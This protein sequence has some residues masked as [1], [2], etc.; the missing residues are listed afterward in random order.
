M[1]T[2]SQLFKPLLNLILLAMPL[3][4]APCAGRAEYFYT[5][6][7]DGLTIYAYDVRGNL[8]IPALINGIRVTGIEAG[9]FQ[10]DDSV[11]SVILPDSVSWV[12]AGAFAS[13]INLT[14]V[15][16]SEGVAEIA[17]WTFANCTSLTNIYIP[18]GVTNIANWAFRDCSNLAAVY[19]RGCP[20]VVAADVFLGAN[21]VT[22]YY[23]LGC[24]GVSTIG[25]RPAVA[26]SF[27]DDYFYGFV[28]D[29]WSQN[30]QAG[31]W[32]CTCG[33]PAAIGEVTI[34]GTFKGLPVTWIYDRAFG[35]IYCPSVTSV[36][37]PAT[38]TRIGDYAFGVCGHMTN[39]NFPPAGDLTSIGQ[40]AFSPCPLTTL[41]LPQAL[42]TIGNSA[43][44]GC[45]ALTQVAFGTNLVRIGDRAFE[46]SNLISV[47]LP[48]SLT[49]IGVG[50]FGLSSQL[51]ALNI[52]PLNP[53]YTSRDGVLFNKSGT[54][55]TAYPM[56]KPELSYTVPVGVTSI[57]PEAF[58]GCMNLA[59]FFQGNA[60]AFDPQAFSSSYNTVLYYLPGTTG[61][62]AAVSGCLQRLWNPAVQ[63]ADP[64][65]GP[66]AGGFGLPIT[67]TANI[68]IVLEV[69]SNMSAGSWTPLQSCTLTN[70]SVFITDLDWTNRPACFYRLRSP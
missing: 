17:A 53:A 63:T 22:A 55:L 11:T 47:D 16:I 7:N 2:A 49:N 23:P 12:G 21:K 13:C 52:D 34:P 25:G 20:P 1:K 28:F 69:S 56:G 6:N 31:F 29:W 27:F 61:W 51:R 40:E 62:E 57:Q 68:P 41:S 10:D 37:I 19:F 8:V 67:G 5:T 59:V 35:Y 66:H 4:L 15:H 54:A 33:Y 50:A 9:T 60:P 26:T 64:A 14:N 24:D 32:E 38:V 18:Y 39:V 48:R 65:F 43:F 45:E 36:N 3:C 30:G 46:A 58:S 42:Q 44:S 70:G